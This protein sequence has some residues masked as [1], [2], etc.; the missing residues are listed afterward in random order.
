[1]KLTDTFC[2]QVA[3]LLNVK[4][5]DIQDVPVTPPPPTPISDRNSGENYNS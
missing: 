2:G 1:M 3:D 4:A 5:G